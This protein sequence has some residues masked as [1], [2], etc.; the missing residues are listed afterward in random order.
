MNID[1]WAARFIKAGIVD[2]DEA[3]HDAKS[4][5]ASRINNDGLRVQLEYLI[6]EIGES[7]LRALLPPQTQ[8]VKMTVVFEVVLDADI[9]LRGLN[10]DMDPRAI[11]VR[12]G[13]SL[14]ELPSKILEWET[15]NTV[16]IDDGEDP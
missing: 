4:T 14:E 2:V 12:R 5:E 3:V 11:T 15:T 10:L 13:F 16:A 9:D 6:E 7:G 8:R 1:K